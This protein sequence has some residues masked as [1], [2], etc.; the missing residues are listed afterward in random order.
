MR[1]KSSQNLVFILSHCVQPVDVKHTVGVD[2]HENASNI[3]VD[4]VTVIP[5]PQIPQQRG[6]IEVRQL[7]HVLHS[8]F[9]KILPDSNLKYSK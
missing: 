8:S 1:G 6:L 7:D 3:G 9:A 4:Q 5:Q 2:S